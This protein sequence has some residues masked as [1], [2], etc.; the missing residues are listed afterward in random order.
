MPDLPGPFWLIGCGNMAGAMLQ[1]WL[2]AGIDASSITVVRPSGAPAPGGVRVLKAFPQG[3]VPALVMLGMKPSMID[4]VAPDVAAALGTDT[5][6]ISILAGVELASL[7][8]RF[9]DCRAI[10][11]AMPNTPVR[12]RKGAIGLYGD[13]DDTAACDT[14]DALMAALGRVE[15][16]DD[17]RML[18]VVTALSGSGPAFVFRFIDALAAAGADLGM[19]PEQAARLALATVEGAG[20]L[21]ASSPESPAVLAER[22]AS[23]G[24]STRK[25]L[26]ILDSDGRLLALLR[27]TLDAA[28]RRNREMA[29]EAR[30][31]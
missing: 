18:D 10:I 21:A 22:V 17:E 30:R 1:G 25:G 7:R 5:I 8:M 31:G 4:Q 24:G 14:V 19:P 9:P 28:V 15:W 26:D 29:A 2:D 20:A 12:L 27:D 13:R 11:R 23:P 3:E 6:V 16:L